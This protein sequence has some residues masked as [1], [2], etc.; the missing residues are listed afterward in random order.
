MRH[1][2]FGQHLNLLRIN[3]PIPIQLLLLFSVFACAPIS[4][5][6][7]LFVADG[8]IL[9]ND[10]HVPHIRDVLK[11]KRKFNKRTSKT[12]SRVIMLWASGHAKPLSE[13][14]VDNVVQP[15]EVVSVQR[16]PAVKYVELFCREATANDLKIS[17]LES[18]SGQ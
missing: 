1:D 2:S 5:P 18:L 16:V 15:L 9:L 4:V 3:D 17:V 12:D 13:E 7:T 8:S 11:V 14:S 10:W 6:V